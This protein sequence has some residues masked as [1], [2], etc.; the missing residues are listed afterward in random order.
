MKVARGR[1]VHRVM[2]PCLGSSI[3]Q[4]LLGAAGAVPQ[5]REASGPGSWAPLVNTQYTARIVPDR[6]I[7]DSSSCTVRVSVWSAPSWALRQVQGC[8]NTETMWKSVMLVGKCSVGRVSS[9]D[10]T[11]RWRHK[12]TLS[13]VLG[14]SISR[15]VLVSPL[16]CLLPRT[17]WLPG[18]IFL[19]FECPYP[20]L[21]RGPDSRGG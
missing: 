7:F 2:A 13:V 18:A 16:R 20:A 6:R 3:C 5:L 12:C 14:I 4:I 19:H 1:A 15:L 8:E 11:P 17:A 10:D 9:P 21:G